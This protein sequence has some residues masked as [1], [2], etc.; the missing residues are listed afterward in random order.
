MHRKNP[1]F[2]RGST[3]WLHSDYNFIAF[4]RF[5]RT[6]HSVILINNNDHEI[7]KEMT[8]WELG[9]P[10]EAEMTR[11]MFTG[12]KG[13]STE[14]VPYE[15]TTGRI[16]VTMPRTSAMVLQYVNEEPVMEKQKVRKNFWQI[17]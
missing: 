17:R 11:L 1:E 4:G 13:F 14:P 12:E 16:T 3:K 5:N 9:I 7:T 15:V 8:V 10:R 2:K 6:H